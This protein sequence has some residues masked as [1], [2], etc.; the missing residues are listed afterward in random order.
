M[1]TR[2]TFLS[3]V[4]CAAALLLRARPEKALGDA[5]QP[6]NLDA[7]VDLCGEL[8]SMTSASAF[9]KRVMVVC[10]VNLKSEEC[11]SPL[12]WEQF[13]QCLLGAVRL[14]FTNLV[15]DMTGDDNEE[16]KMFFQMLS[17]FAKKDTPND[18]MTMS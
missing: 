12:H 15:K 6:V 11:K 14:N 5:I 8:D 18:E 16:F 4:V 9:E 10:S 13:R 17:L 3:N 2:G 1:V 7:L